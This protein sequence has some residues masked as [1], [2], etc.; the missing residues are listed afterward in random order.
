MIQHHQDGGHVRSAINQNDVQFPKRLFQSELFSY[1]RN[2]QQ[3]HIIFV[4]WVYENWTLLCNGP[5]QFYDMWALDLSCEALTLG[6]GRACATVEYINVNNAR[7]KNLWR[8][9]IIYVNLKPFSAIWR[10]E[11]HFMAIRLNLEP[12]IVFSKCI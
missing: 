8:Q 4:S 9:N 12:S 11:Y 7:Y 1:L 6:F 2:F 3:P 5:F 10:F